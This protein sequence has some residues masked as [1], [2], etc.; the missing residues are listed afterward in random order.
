MARGTQILA[1]LLL[2]LAFVHFACEGNHYSCLAGQSLCLIV[3]GKPCLRLLLLLLVLLA[4]VLPSSATQAIVVGLL[5]ATQNNVTAFAGADAARVGRQLAQKTDPKEP[6]EVKQAS[7]QS[8]QGGG[9][10]KAAGSSTQ[11]EY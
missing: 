2:A 4:A 10:T 1:T 7:S 3:V 5:P 11:R 8:T 9:C 6:K